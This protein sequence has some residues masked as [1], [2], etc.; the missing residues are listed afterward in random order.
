MVHHQMVHII[1]NTLIL[2][3]YTCFGEDESERAGARRVSS[4]NA[5][6]FGIVQRAVYAAR[7][8]T[9]SVLLNLMVHH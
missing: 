9:T 1:K 2:A 3:R 6:G 4:G 7:Q 8:E 5:Q